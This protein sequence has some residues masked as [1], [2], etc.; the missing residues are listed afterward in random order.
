MSDRWSIDG[1]VNT[2]K[3]SDSVIDAEG[4][5]ALWIQKGVATIDGED[6]PIRHSW[7]DR[8]D[9]SPPRPLTRAPTDIDPADVGGRVFAG[10]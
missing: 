7:T 6:K 9:G 5:N 3:T 2:E 4:K 10:R 8:F 1:V